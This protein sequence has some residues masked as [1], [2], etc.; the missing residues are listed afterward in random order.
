M[1]VLNVGTS[2]IVSC[3]FSTYFTVPRFAQVQLPNCLTARAASLN[4]P[5]ADNVEKLEVA[6]PET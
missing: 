4:T 6:A 2:R 5:A 3:N 1:Q